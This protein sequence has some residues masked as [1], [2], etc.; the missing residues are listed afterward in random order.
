MM[1]EI[2]DAVAGPPDVGGGDLPELQE[3]LFRHRLVR[4]IAAAV[5][6]AVVVVVPHRE[7]G[8]G[9][10]QP[11]V[12][13]DAF[14]RFVGALEVGR[15]FA[16]EVA[17]DIVASKDEKLGPIGENG[18]PDRLRLG[19][20]GAG[21]EGNARQRRAALCRDG[22]RRQ[23]SGG[24]E[25]GEGAA[26]EHQG[27]RKARIA[28]LVGTIMKRH[29]KYLLELAIVPVVAAVVFIEDV[30]LHYLGLAMASLAKWPPVA[31]LE[32]WLR[33]LAA[34]GRLGGLRG[35]VGAR[36]AGQTSRCLVR[37]APS[38]RAFPRQC[39]HRQ[40]AGDGVWSRAL[41]G[42]A[43]DLGDHAMVRCGRRPGCSPGATGSMPSCAPCRP[44]R[45]GRAVLQRVRAWMRQ[46]VSGAAPR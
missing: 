38:L 39:C 18:I 16:A 1:L 41:P 2:V 11:V 46:L 13:G 42:A 23:G 33:G 19:L 6:D 3:Q 22:S 29:L 15:I 7:M 9:L 5:V 45:S 37:A 10:A 8:D 4:E 30:L 12:A 25:L 36:S 17:V 27:H 24:H 40:D 32:A 21:A 44:G 31:R 26:V 14:R 34:V 20:V 28:G 43:S 35:A